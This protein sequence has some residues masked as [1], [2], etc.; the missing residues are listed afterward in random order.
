MEMLLCCSSYGNAHVDLG[1]LILGFSKNGFI[2]ALC[3]LDSASASGILV[4]LLPCLLWFRFEH[5]LC[6]LLVAVRLHSPR[7]LSEPE[8]LWCGPELVLVAYP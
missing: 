8:V 6:V 7:L 1:F 5:A 2:G 4:E 3:R